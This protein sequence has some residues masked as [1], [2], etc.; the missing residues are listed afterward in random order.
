MSAITRFL[1]LHSQIACL[2]S[3]TSSSSI[4]LLLLKKCFHYIVQHFIIKHTFF[5]RLDDI[6]RKEWDGVNKIYL[7]RVTL[8]CHK[9]IFNNT[10]HISQ[11][12]CGFQMAPDNPGV[13][14]LSD[15]QLKGSHVVLFFS[16]ISYFCKYVGSKLASENISF[17]PG[18]L[19]L[20]KKKHPT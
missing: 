15:Q 7:K 18:K 2:S 3:L 8:H 16:L 20:L 11:D 14:F 19:D 13:P 4:L 5:S 9:S 10:I 1:I 17:L 12:P 6:F